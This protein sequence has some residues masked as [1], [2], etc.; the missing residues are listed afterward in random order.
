[1]RE[2]PEKKR[3]GWKDK[4]NEYVGG[5]KDGRMIAWFQS[6]RQEECGCS[7]KVITVYFVH[8]H[9]HTALTAHYHDLL[10]QLGL[11]ESRV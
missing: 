3:R 1:M 4:K 2:E 7:S 6:V 5:M 8:T 11:T 10:S 9:T